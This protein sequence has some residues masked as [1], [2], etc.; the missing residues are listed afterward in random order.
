MFYIN[1]NNSNIRYFAYKYIKKNIRFKYYQINIISDIV[2]YI[3]TYL[4]Y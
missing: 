2:E 4:N 1:Y 3:Y